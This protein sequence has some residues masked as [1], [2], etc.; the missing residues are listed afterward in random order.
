MEPP[1]ANFQN[2]SW[3]NYSFSTKHYTFIFNQNWV[4]IDKKSKIII[5]VG[6]NFSIGQD[7]AT[8]HDDKRHHARP[9]VPSTLQ[10]R[11]KN[12]IARL[13][14]A[15]QARLGCWLDW[16]GSAQ[17]FQVGWKQTRSG[18]TWFGLGQLGQP[19]LGGSINNIERFGSSSRANPWAYLKVFK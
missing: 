13:G 19:I 5:P 10:A 15:W 1:S 8:S 11:K 17:A 9:H 16:L 14:C 18:S 6:P 12:K 2:I 4:S 7:G 3:F